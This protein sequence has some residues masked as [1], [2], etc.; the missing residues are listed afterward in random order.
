MFVR[1]LKLLVLKP[2]LVKTEKKNLPLSYWK[3]FQEV[4]TFL[5]VLHS[6]GHDEYMEKMLSFFLIHT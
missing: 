2:G 4:H 5:T 1:S 6:W 3:T